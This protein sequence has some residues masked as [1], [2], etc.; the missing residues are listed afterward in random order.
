MFAAE[1]NYL[2]AD[3]VGV[4]HLAFVA[5]VVV[6]QLLIAAGW[7]LGWRRELAN[8]IGLTALGL[9]LALGWFVG[10]RTEI[11]L[12]IALAAL[13]LI[14]FVGWV[15]GWGWIRN[16]WFR[17]IHLTSIG[18]VAAEGALG[19]WC[20]LT[21]WERDFRNGN[22]FD[23][24]GSSWLGKVA[25]QILFYQVSDPGYIVW[26]QRG[27]IAFGVLVLVTFVFCFPRL[28][29]RKT[30]PAGKAPAPLPSSHPTHHAPANGI[31]TSQS[32]ISR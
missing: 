25:N 26:F 17:T 6:G 31:T 11:P 22:M 8:L 24:S 20:P 1:P 15:F 7:V 21:M 14:I 5:F 30:A 10:W 3:L 19:I 13:M 28:P 23:L 18:I 29:W 4:I 2:M 12:F 9:L 27:H 32:P 16:F